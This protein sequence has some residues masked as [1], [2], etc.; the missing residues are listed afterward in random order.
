MKVKDIM[1]EDVITV[2]VNETIL[3]VAKLMNDY[4]IGCIPVAEEDK[5]VLGMIT[6]RDIVIAMA[7]YDLNPEEATVKN[8]MTSEV[9]SVE[10]DTELSHALDL[11]RKQ[12]IRRIPVIENDELKGILSLGDIAVRGDQASA[13]IAEALT[14]ISQPWQEDN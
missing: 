7:K 13:E 3:N 5:K 8:V 1:T 2:G 4:N 14:E 6:D 11:M 9:F 10:P 12:K